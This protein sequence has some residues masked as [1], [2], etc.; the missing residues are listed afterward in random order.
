[1]ANLSDGEVIGVLN[2]YIADAAETQRKTDLFKYAKD[3]IER[4]GVAQQALVGYEKQ[5]AD[6]VRS[7][8]S[9]NEQWRN[10]DTAAQKAHAAKLAQYEETEKDYRRRVDLALTDLK[11]AGDQLTAFKAGDALERQTLDAASVEAKKALAT[12]QTD[13]A[14]LKQKYGLGGS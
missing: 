11:N 6:L 12:L 4:F 1:M 7:L 10:T 5:K 8:D 3:V 2:R 14:T 9:L 13:I